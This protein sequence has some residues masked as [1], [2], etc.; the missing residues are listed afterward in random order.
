MLATASKP[1]K[2]LVTGPWLENQSDNGVCFV[3]VEH[4]AAAIKAMLKFIYSS[5]KSWFCKK[6]HVH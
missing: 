3:K 1:L 6:K 5:Q 2:A 4:S